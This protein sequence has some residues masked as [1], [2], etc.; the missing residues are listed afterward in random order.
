MNELLNTLFGIGSGDQAIGFG[1]PDAHP[2]F[3]YA[4]PGWSILLIIMLLMGLALW[5]YRALPGSRG[6]RW[7]LGLLRASTLVL[8]FLLALGPRIEQTQ[9]ENEPDWVLVLLDRST[10]LDTPDASA[11][12]S[13]RDRQLRDMLTDAGEPWTK[14]AEN[15][16]VLWFGFDDQA[17]LLAEGEAFDP[18]AVA[19][20]NGQGTDIDLAIR[21][22]LRQAAARPVS[23]IVIA[24]DGRVTRSIDPELIDS[25]AERQIPIVSVPLGST[26]PVRDLAINR[27]DHPDAVFGKDIAPI[28][29]QLGARGFNEDDLQRHP[30]YIELVD[31]ER[32]EVLDR[33]RIDESNLGADAQAVTLTHTPSDEGDRRLDIR[34]VSDRATQD[35]NPTNDMRSI[36]MRVVDRPLRVLYIDG[37]PRWEQRYIKAML[38]REP[39]IVSSSL[40]LSATRRY[41]QEGDELI[42][43][44]PSTIEGW[45]PFDVIVLGDVRPEMFS[46]QQLETMREHVETRG[47]GLL[48]LAGPTSVPDAYLSTA[49]T[50]LLPMR[51]DAGGSQPTTRIW[52][53]P[54]TM[55]ASPEAA[56][57][58]VLR[59]SDDG[60]GWLQRLSDPGTGW[61]ELNW[62]VAL[63][64]TSFKPGVSVLAHAIGT[65]SQQEAPI[66]TM[67][68]Y[69]A[70][71]SAFVATDEIWRWRYGRGEDLP[72][73]FWLPLI[74]SLGR[75]TVARRAAPAQLIITPNEP[76]PGQ[77]AQ[78]TMRLF[79]QRRIDALPERIR[80]RVTSLADRSEPAEIELSG[81]GDTRTGV[82]VPPRA[83]NF[84]IRPVGL[85][86]QMSEIAQRS[87]V[88]Q[89]A[90][91][92]RQL[93]SD[94]AL[95]ESISASTAG[96]VT[97]PESFAE[98]PS[99]LPNRART[100]VSPP[101]RASLWDRPIVL[102][103]LVSLLTLE[104]I[105]RRT[106]RLA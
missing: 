66:I 106:L 87:R 100:I 59:L 1:T 93:D 82:W 27:V 72:E 96:W 91:E 50:A 3:T 62:A 77:A 32:D 104:W 88:Y 55:R 70:G 34:I 20:P 8:L 37:Y 53:E 6:A 81:V 86:A 57:L 14:L 38:L 9:I 43:S 68:R 10:S 69:G 16:R 49:L 92:R 36:E 2:G 105:G 101:R 99:K 4:L 24:S 47:A 44:I 30:A 61:S 83:G 58:G 28:R 5:S 25:L 35:L 76:A 95:L 33:V 102:I 103:V 54:V 89:R 48:W 79:D 63:D 7:G 13:D 45:E 85:D 17:R 90:D 84:E 23:A 29:V 74:R 80:V 31:H 19:E 73:R 67:M 46:T 11:A 51:S 21:T 41:I 26:D 97:Q 78:V 64:D 40:L 42:A 60:E 52:G 22:A 94:H 65:R 15:K 56:R 39:S 98:I 12:G 71:A 18:L 75:G